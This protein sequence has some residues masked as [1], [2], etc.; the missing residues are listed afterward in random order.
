MMILEWEK[1][2]GDHLLVVTNVNDEP[3]LTWRIKKKQNFHGVLRKNIG[4]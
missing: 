3:E 4:L 1:L 2:L